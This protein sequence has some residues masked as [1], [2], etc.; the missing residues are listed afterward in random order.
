MFGWVLYNGVGNIMMFLN[1]SIHS[2]HFVFN[3]T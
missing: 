1:K 3:V 2:V